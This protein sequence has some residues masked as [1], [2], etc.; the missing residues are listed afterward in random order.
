V[1]ARCAMP[2][3][4]QTGHAGS[5]AARD[6]DGPPAGPRE[7]RARGRRAGR[8]GSE[9][10]MR[11]PPSLPLP[12]ACM[13]D[14][15]TS[16]PTPVRAHNAND[17]YNIMFMPGS[18]V[19]MAPVVVRSRATLETGQ[20][21]ACASPRSRPRIHMRERGWPIC[22]DGGPTSAARPGHLLADHPTV[23]TSTTLELPSCNLH[24]PRS[25]SPPMHAP[26]PT[27][28][29]SAAARLRMHVSSRH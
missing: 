3:P 12:T 5:G 1:H 17:C 23:S 11:T 18:A 19:P 21:E 28:H 7:R 16:A 10:D 22:D 4:A 20:C 6:S 13:P 15:P 9:C 24:R 26:T 2:M 25:A 14:M 29:N 8:P 27:L